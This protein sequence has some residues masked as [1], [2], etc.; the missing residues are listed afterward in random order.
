MTAEV[1][2]ATA[3]PESRAKQAVKQIIGLLLAFVFLWLAFR[4]TNFAEIWNQMQGI[5]VGWMAAVC[6]VCVLSHWLRAVRWVIMLKPLA[7][8]PISVWNSFCAVMVGYAVNIAV[9]RGGEVARVV[10]ISK[11]EKLPWVGV[12]PTLLI[13][14]LL[15]VAMLV[16]LLG[17]TLVMLPADMRESTKWLVPAGAVLCALTVIGLG[18]LPFTG[19]IMKRI[20]GLEAVRSRLPEKVSYMAA[21]LSEQFDRGTS[22]LRSPAGLVGIALLS[23]AIWGAYFA[24]FYLAILAFNMQDQ[25]DLGRSLVVFS[26]SSVAVLVPTPGSLGTFHYATTQALEKVSHIGAAQGMAFATVFHAVSFVLVVC[27]VAAIC[28]VVQQAADKSDKQAIDG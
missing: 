2:T 3:A 9:P 22:S 13:D 19:V 14:R 15:D 23:V 21:D 25:V 10:S 18:V 16:L 8:K 4:N 7:H 28:F 6:A 24:S 5:N 27:I 17:V 11:T 26:I 1:P 20:L 12:V